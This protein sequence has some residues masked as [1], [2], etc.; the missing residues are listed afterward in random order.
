MFTWIMTAHLFENKILGVK[1]DEQP[2]G[3]LIDNFFQV[4]NE[5]GR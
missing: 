3:I 4:V 2:G 5:L 1:S